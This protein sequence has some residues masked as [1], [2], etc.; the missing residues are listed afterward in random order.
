MNKTQMRDVVIALE[1]STNTNRM[2]LEIF[3][4]SDVAIS[5]SVG[6]TESVVLILFLMCMCEP[7][8]DVV[9]GSGFCPCKKSGL[10][11]WDINAADDSGHLGPLGN[12]PCPK[13]RTNR[14]PAR[15]EG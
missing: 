7:V 6:I 9:G 11:D 3:G 15:A 1:N 2:C 8:F 5:R 13:R 10:N 14:P 4:V 12:K